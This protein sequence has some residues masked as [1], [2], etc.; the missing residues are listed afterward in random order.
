MA[1]CSLQTA[2]AFRA[3][4]PLLGLLTTAVCLYIVTKRPALKA[5]FFSVTPRPI[6]GTLQVIH[7]CVHIPVWARQ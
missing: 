6:N 1:I 4:T 3:S 2:A 7:A 5:E